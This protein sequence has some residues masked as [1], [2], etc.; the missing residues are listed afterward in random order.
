[1]L[2]LLLV[3]SAGSSFVEAGQLSKSALVGKLKNAGNC[4][5]PTKLANVIQDNASKR[6]LTTAL[7]IAAVAVA[8]KEAVTF[9]VDQFQ[10]DAD[11]EFE[12]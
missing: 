9:A 7:V 8:T 6:P 5:Y 11:K 12:F 1:M 10:D 4:L 2:S 3:L